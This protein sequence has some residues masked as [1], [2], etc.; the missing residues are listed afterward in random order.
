MRMQRRPHQNGRRSVPPS[1]FTSAHFQDALSQS[2]YHVPRSSSLRMPS[3]FSGSPL[4]R[5]QSQ[6]T[7]APSTRFC[8]WTTA[9][10]CLCLSAVNSVTR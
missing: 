5:T 7:P 8:N 3:S 6:P 9:A 10:R 1:I 4:R 2:G